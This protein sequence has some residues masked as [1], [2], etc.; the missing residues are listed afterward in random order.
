MISQDARVKERKKF[1]FCNSI[2]RQHSIMHL[3]FYIVMTGVA[4]ASGGWV[5]VGG[6]GGVGGMGSWSSY[7]HCLHL[8]SVLC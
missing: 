1:A 6:W 2:A 7:M 4:S 5:G 3:K 8:I